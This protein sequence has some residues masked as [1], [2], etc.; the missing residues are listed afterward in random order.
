[1]SKMRVKYPA[2]MLVHGVNDTRVDVWQSAKFAARM[3]AANQGRA[4][5]SRC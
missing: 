4:R 5:R 2:V 1:M 3:L